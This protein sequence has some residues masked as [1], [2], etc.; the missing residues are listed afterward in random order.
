MIILGLSEVT[1]LTGIPST[2]LLFIFIDTIHHKKVR[3]LNDSFESSIN[4]KMK[5][6]VVILRRLEFNC[7][8][9]QIF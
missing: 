9:L 6:E 1:N 4:I 8:K 3:T 7:N 2:G 5:K